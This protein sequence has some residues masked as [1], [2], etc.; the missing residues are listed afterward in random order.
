MGL[1]PVAPLQARLEQG[2]YVVEL[3]P[4]RRVIVPAALQERPER[5]E[6]PGESAWPE[7]LGG[8]HVGDLQT[9]ALGFWG[10]GRRQAIYCPVKEGVVPSAKAFS[11]VV[12]W[13][14]NLG[15]R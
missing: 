6:V 11:R 5:P 14:L 10:M 8:D 15:S 9:G 3:G 13:R 1:G 12:L 7:A 4:L 2:H